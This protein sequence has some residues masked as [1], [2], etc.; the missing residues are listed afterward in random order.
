MVSYTIYKVLKDNIRQ[1]NPYITEMPVA[2]DH[3]TVYFA[4]ANAF[5]QSNQVFVGSVDQFVQ[6]GVE[7]GYQEQGLRDA[8]MQLERY[9]FLTL[10]GDQFIP[11]D[12]FVDRFRS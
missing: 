8:F 3:I 7:A 2:G 12:L 11:T 9:G 1:F 6:L 10:E 4:I 5:R